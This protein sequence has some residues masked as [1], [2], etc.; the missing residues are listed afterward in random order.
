MMSTDTDLIENFR[1]GPSVLAE[2]LEGVSE[3]ESSFSP[4]PGKWTI[5]EIVRHLADTEIV[6][7]MRLRQIIS[8][9]HPALAVFDQDAWA[10]QLGYA[11]YD[12]FESLAV[13]RVLREI[14]AALIAS[15][16]SEA[17][18]REGFHPERG[19]LTVR[20]WI[21]RFTNHVDTHARQ[22]RNIRETWAANGRSAHA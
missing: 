5:R 1:G 14:N 12:A 8:E 15:V 22:I 3:A 20:D 19:I 17:L 2:T 11:K 4:A 21:I 9:H 18:D 16:P 6:A 13:F 7:G 10:T